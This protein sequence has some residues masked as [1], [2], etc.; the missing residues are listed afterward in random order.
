M[1]SVYWISN[2]GNEVLLLQYIRYK[3]ILA[4]FYCVCTQ[5]ALFLRPL[6]NPTSDS[7]HQISYKGEILAI[8]IVYS[9]IK[10]S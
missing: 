9:D 10:L 1:D 3:A 7:A 5:C 6:E 8:A 2:K 4:K